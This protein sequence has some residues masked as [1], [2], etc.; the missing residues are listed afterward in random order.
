MSSNFGWLFC[1]P[2]VF[3]D[4]V[5]MLI[6]HLF[7][8]CV[9]RRQRWIMLVTLLRRNSSDN[10]PLL[11]KICTS[12]N[13]ST[14][15]IFRI[16]TIWRL[17]SW[18]SGT[19]NIS[20]LLQSMKQGIRHGKLKRRWEF[21]KICPIHIAW[22]RS[23]KLRSRSRSRSRSSLEIVIAIAIAI[24]IWKTTTIAAPGSP[25][26]TSYPKIA[27]NFTSFYVAEIF[28]LL[29]WNLLW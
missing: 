7:Q 25:I 3:I 27:T 28:A 14:T 11:K 15:R 24:S 29:L 21:V 10:S 4:G 2:K 8:F 23:P 1:T 18:G 9:T 22:P 17:I 13:A 5:I 19:R 12:W 6:R 20:R 16:G 26:G